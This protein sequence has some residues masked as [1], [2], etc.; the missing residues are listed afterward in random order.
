[1]EKNKISFAFVIFLVL[2]N[3]RG[4]S[5]N[6]TGNS[7]DLWCKKWE[8]KHIYFAED[9][10]YFN[11]SFAFVKIDTLD[12]LKIDFEC[13]PT[14]YNIEYLKIY[15]NKNIFLN[16]DLNLS[17]IINIFNRR[18]IQTDVVLENVKG[19]NENSRS[20]KNMMIN[21]KHI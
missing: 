16:N 4:N 13:Q 3:F 20:I 9:V 1:M 11:K 2:Y 6:L 19:F 8:R 7:S 5:H 14:E 18:S 17:G 12:E 10:H 15:A 21:S